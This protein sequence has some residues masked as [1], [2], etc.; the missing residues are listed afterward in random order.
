MRGSG[1]QVEY[2]SHGKRLTM[3]RFRRPAMM[4]ALVF[5]AAAST[6]IAGATPSAEPASVSQYL[7][8]LVPLEKPGP[9]RSLAPVYQAALAAQTDLM[10]FSND[11]AWIETL[12]DADFTALQARMKGFVLSRGLDIYANP[13]PGFFLALAQRRGEPA[14][15]AFFSLVAKTTGEDHMAAYM[16][17]QGRGL[18]I[19]YGENIIAPYYSAWRDY[20]KKF[21]GHYAHEVSQALADVEDSVGLG[22]CACGDIE[23]VRKELNGFVQQFP[24]TPI[25]EKIGDR[26]KQLDEDPYKLPVGCT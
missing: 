12:S 22:T 5:A 8:Q 19:R 14:D 20:Q 25:K 23:T 18:C 21:P 1:T 7:A 2:D 4:L 9:K 3:K 24:S 6:V 26:L 13:D 17:Y 16:K 11:L 15:L 10:A